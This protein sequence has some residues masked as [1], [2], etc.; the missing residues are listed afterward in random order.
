MAI[1]DSAVESRAS[2]GF[3]VPAC[4]WP[5]GFGAGAAPMEARVDDTGGPCRLLGEGVEGREGRFGCGEK[6]GA[7]GSSV[8]VAV[9]RYGK[10]AGR[11]LYGHSPNENA[12]GLPICVARAISSTWYDPA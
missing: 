5:A 12:D 2:L 1:L 3:F 4:Y 8:D 6:A 9:G 11:M 7:A 10:T